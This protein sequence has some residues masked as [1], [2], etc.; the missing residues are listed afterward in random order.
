[1][2]LLQCYSIFSNIQKLPTCF[3]LLQLLNQIKFQKQHNMVTWC[4]FTT[5]SVGL[6][7][8]LTTLKRN[9]KQKISM[10]PWKVPCRLDLK[11]DIWTQY[12]LHFFNLIQWVTTWERTKLETSLTLYK[13]YA[14]SEN[15]CVV[16]PFRNSD[17]V[18]FASLDIKKN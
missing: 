16:L 11:F 2:E 12:K 15:I 5:N 10:H 4:E 6:Q 17:T 8:T 14:D 18:H 13:F 9:F 7:Q 3:P 1:M